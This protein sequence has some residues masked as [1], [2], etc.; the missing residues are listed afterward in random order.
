MRQLFFGFALM[1]LA[2][3]VSYSFEIDG[4]SSGMSMEKAK[5]NLEGSSYKNIQTREN[6]IIA[7]GGNRF[8]LLN[9]CKNELVM[10]QKHLAPDFGSFVRLIDEKR[11]ELGKPADAW[12]EPADVNFPVERNAVSFLWRDSSTSVKVTFTE[13]SSNRQLDILYE[14][15]NSCRQ[16]LD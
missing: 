7:S 4:L 13:F 11:R 9:F 16:V 10:V 3:N 12:T 5:K 14:I 2:A 6:G 8:I 15:K 1:L